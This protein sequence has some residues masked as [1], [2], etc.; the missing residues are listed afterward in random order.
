[1]VVY[2]EIFIKLHMFISVIDFQNYHR[3]RDIKHFML[4]LLII[5]EIEFHLITSNLFVV[6]QKH[7]DKCK[8]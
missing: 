2:V 7:Q 1:M 5:F 8:V 6:V 4:N 3:L